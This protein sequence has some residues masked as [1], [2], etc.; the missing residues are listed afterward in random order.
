[1]V[2]ARVEALAEPGGICITRP[3]RDQIR[4]KL[5]YE[6]EDLGDISVKNI[7]RPVRVFKVLVDTS[8]LPLAER[9]QLARPRLRATMRAGALAAAVLLATG[10]WT[11]VATPP[12]EEAPTQLTRSDPAPTQIASLPPA[13][14]VAPAETLE[15]APLEV[16]PRPDEIAEI[17]ADAVG[18]TAAAES[19]SF[20]ISFDVNPGAWPSCAIFGGA[21]RH[22]LPLGAGAE[23]TRIPFRNGPELD[24]L[25]KARREEEEVVLTLLPYSDVWREQDAMRI[26][27]P[28]ASPGAAARVFSSKRAMPPLTSCGRLVAYV[29]VVE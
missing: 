13:A 6:L 26:R 11:E 28:D 12:Q 14:T 3:V 25:A 18:A 27:L 4:D 10:I 22:T 8:V 19:I 29:N 9:G 21:E 5:G 2:A 20:A 16:L 24:L 1:N 23:W 7:A 15:L 17:A